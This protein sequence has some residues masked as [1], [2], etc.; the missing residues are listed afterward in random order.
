MSTISLNS[1]LSGLKAA[2]NAL[3]TV[4]TNISNAQTVGYTRKILPQQTSLVGGIGQGVLNGILTRKVDKTLQGYLIKQM[5]TTSGSVVRQNYLQQISDFNGAAESQNAISFKIGNLAQSFARLSESPN[6]QLLLQSTLLSAQDVAGKFNEYSNLINSMRN[7]ANNQ[8]NDTVT[9]INT[10]LRDLHQINARIGNLNGS[11]QSTADLE[12]QRDLLVRDLSKVMDIS[13]Y[14]TDGNRIVVLTKRGLPLVDEGVHQLKFSAGAI[15]PGSFYPGGGANGIFVDDLTRPSNEIPAA[16]IGGEFGALMEMRDKTLPQYQAQLDEMAQKMA[17]R[18]D[19]MGLRLFSDASGNIP[20]N[21]TPPAPTGYTGFA[22]VMRVNPAVVA[23]PTLIRNGTYGDTYPAGSNEMIRKISEY[24]FGN[25]AYLRASG[26]ANISAGT[27]FGSLGLSQVN[28]IVG[29]VNLNSYTP[30]LDAAP[31]ITAPASFTLNVG[32]LPYNI[33]IAPGDTAANLVTNINT[34]V[35]STVASLD[36][37]GR[38]VLNSSST[39]IISNGTLGAAGLADLGLTAGTYTPSNPSLTVR[40]GSQAPVTISIGPA[41]T[42][43][44]LLAA[45]NAIPGMSASLGPCGVLQMQP[46]RGGDISVQNGLGDPIGALGMSISP[47]AHPAFRTSNMR[48]N[49]SISSNIN[50]TNTLESYS[51]TF[52]S[53]QA[54]DHSRAKDVQER[55]ESFFQTLDTRLSNES[56][57][58]IDEEVAELVRIQSAYTAAARAIS[59]TEQL[60]DELLNIF[61]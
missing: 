61:N 33:N 11:G 50:G 29:T 9:R 48:A 42:A 2:Q 21:T 56:G 19:T 44:T 41:D 24:A 58:N 37:T 7:D 57:V 60:M 49:G 16:E 59:I 18:F 45:L 15:T 4:S 35:G 30:D 17:Q 3:N 32:G 22:G 6:N 13:I 54:E 36:G 8:I 1:A 14:T 46:T 47:V 20:A 39:M 26:T 40:V 34:A 27:L 31:N 10:T 25:N 53:G 28:K 52:I 51:R 55:E 38:L 43:A 12:D 5:G 23:D